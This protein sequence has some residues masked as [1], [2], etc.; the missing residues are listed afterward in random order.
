MREREDWGGVGALTGSSGESWSAGES[1]RLKEAQMISLDFLSVS[2]ILQAVKRAASAASCE[3]IRFFAVLDMGGA[4]T[5]DEVVFVVCV[6][7]AE[8]MVVD[9]CSIECS[10]RAMDCETVEGKKT[11]N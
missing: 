8:F 5:Y 1:L 6:D 9:T 7:E 3:F 2:S 11:G 10:H 4:S